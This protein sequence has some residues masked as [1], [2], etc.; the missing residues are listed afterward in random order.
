MS[1]FDERL[2]ELYETELRYLRYAGADF[3]R[4]FPKLAARLELGSNG[5]ADPHIERLLESFAFLTARMHRRVEDDLARVPAALLQCLYPSLA[6]PVPGMAIANFSVSDE[7]PPPPTGVTVPRESM[8][9]A[10][11]EEGQLCRLR[12]GYDVDLHP[13]ALSG[14]RRESAGARDLFDRGTVDAVIRMRVHGF[15]APLDSV[16]ADKLRLF[17]AGPRKHATLVQELLLAETAELKAVDPETGRAV[18]LGAD[19]LRHVGFGADEAVLPDDVETHPAQRLVKEY[20]ILPE[21]FLFLDLNNF[22]RRPAGTSVDLLFGLRR[23]PPSW[24]DLRAVQPTLGCTPVINLFKVTAE[25][26]PLHHQSTEY[27]VVPELGAEDFHEVHSVKTVEVTAPGESAP[28]QIAP[29]FGHPH[30]SAGAD[31]PD[32]YW[33]AR[34]DL[35]GNGRPGSDVFVGFVEPDMQSARPSRETATVHTWCTNRLLTEQLNAGARLAADFEVPAEISL[36]DRAT[37]PVPAVH[38]ADTLWQL[39][40]QLSLSHLSLSSH[41]ES[42]RHVERLRDMLR[43][44]CPPH[45]PESVREIMGITDIS[46]RVVVRRVGRDVWRGFCE[47]LEVTLTL[48][49]SNFAETSAYLFASVLRQVLSLH[50]VANTFVE[51]VLVSRQRE[52]VWKRW[53]P[54]IGGQALI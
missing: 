20:F 23:R 18:N 49:E 6:D 9:Y 26:I 38:D 34:R 39:V 2:L 14:L 31:A 42:Q 44:H 12:T 51:L 13:L 19:S 15:G 25:P 32:M 53:T 7:V 48:D 54:I 45:R 1:T 16:T 50:A 40:S 3:A 21:K 17:L 46:T 36:I 4:R 29:Y 11:S 10:Q 30:A 27:R 22:D 47:G 5:S 28:R 43:L 35:A 41:D 37:T 33:L 52:G 24:L 8:L